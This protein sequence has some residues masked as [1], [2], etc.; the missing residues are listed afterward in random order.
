MAVLPLRIQHLWRSF[1]SAGAWELGKQSLLDFVFPPRCHLCDEPFPNEVPASML[2]EACRHLLSPKSIRCCSFC[3]AE[4]AKDLPV[5]TRC[6][7]CRGETFHFQAVTSL[8]AYRGSLRNVVLAM[9]RQSSGIL[10]FS[11]ATF[12]WERNQAAF[13]E[14]NPDLILPVP[15]HRWRRLRRGVNPADALAERLARLLEKPGVSGGLIR[16]RPTAPQTRLTPPQRRRNVRHAFR[17]ARKPHYF[18]G[19]RILLVDDVLTT[20]AT[21]NEIAATLLHSGVA[22]VR[23]VVLARATGQ[24]K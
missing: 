8:G 15:M 22:E 6:G 10:A 16:C 9:K 12:L 20:G 1:F 11:M 17:L 5:G 7:A 19:K 23:V 4:V 21:C 18:E 2:C 13:A 24:R 3:G 14:F